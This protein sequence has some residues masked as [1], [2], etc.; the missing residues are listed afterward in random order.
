MLMAGLVLGRISVSK[1]AGIRLV[2]SDPLLENEGEG[3]RSPVT[4]CH[5]NFAGGCARVWKKEET[6][7]SAVSA[8][9]ESRA[10]QA[11]AECGWSE[12]Q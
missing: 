10:E 1:R 5:I 4:V 6:F 8:G 12:V 11:R 9:P 2:A 3:T 7:R